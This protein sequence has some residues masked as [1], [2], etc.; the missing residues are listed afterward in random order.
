MATMI[1][2]MERTSRTV[3]YIVCLLVG[4][5]KTNSWR[6][7]FKEPMSLSEKVTEEEEEESGKEKRIFRER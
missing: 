3:V 7:A 4:R 5:R 1:A 6:N 2:Q